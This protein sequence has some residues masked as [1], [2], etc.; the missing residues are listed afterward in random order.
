MTAGVMDTARLIAAG[1]EKREQDRN[2]GTR[3]EARARVARRMGVM[4]GTL[5]NLAANRLKKLDEAFKKRLT[6]YAVADLE[7]EIE[8]Y[9]HDLELARALGAPKDPETVRRIKAALES[10][11]ALYDEAMRDGGVA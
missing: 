1:C 5:Y 10:A 8:G 2:G 11:Q 7:R 6:A 4:P 3:P 9:R